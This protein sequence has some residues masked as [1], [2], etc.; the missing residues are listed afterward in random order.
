MAPAQVCSAW[1]SES[2]PSDLPVAGR[3]SCWRRRRRS[4]CPLVGGMVDVAS[5]ELVVPARGRG[6]VRRRGGGAR[7]GRRTAVPP[8]SSPGVDPMGRSRTRRAPDRHP[9]RPVGRNHAMRSQR[10][11]GPAEARNPA[12]SFAASSRSTARACSCLVRSSSRPRILCRGSSVRVG[13]LSGQEDSNGVPCTV[14]P[15]IHLRC[16]AARKALGRRAETAW[17]RAL[18]LRRAREEPPG[19]APLRPRRCS[20]PPRHLVPPRGSPGE[21]G[22]GVSSSSPG[23][24]GICRVHAGPGERMRRSVSTRDRGLDAADPP[25]RPGRPRHALARGV[26]ADRHRRMFNSTAKWAPDRVRRPDPGVAG[27]RVLGRN[28]GPAGARRARAARGHARG[29]G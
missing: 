29:R 11:G 14:Q 24:P 9:A 2:E 25:D 4:G 13:A 23:R 6:R 17:C 15:A 1:A 28:G 20:D 18:A 19:P 21:H 12:A 16:C 26:P 5:G 7:S 8:C 22:P 3:R 10:D 27:P